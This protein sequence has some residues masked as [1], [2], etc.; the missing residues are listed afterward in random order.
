MPAGSR[1]SA[2]AARSLQHTACPPT[3]PCHG[4]P[5]RPPG[6]AAPRAAAAP[7]ARAAPP[8]PWPLPLPSCELP[9]VGKEGRATRKTAQQECGS[10]TP[11]QHH[12]QHRMPPS[13]ATCLQPPL[14]QPPDLAAQRYAPAC[15][16][17]TPSLLSVHTTQASRPTHLCCIPAHRLHLL[18]LPLALRLLGRLLGLLRLQQKWWQRQQAH[19]GM[20]RG[21]RA[22]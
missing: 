21:T 16:S 15:P 5:Q 10:S 3:H 2:G 17:T 4:L 1:G 20:Q 7:P 9:P 22:A 8:P 12:R 11:W 18:L 6:T 13:P 19:V 14:Q